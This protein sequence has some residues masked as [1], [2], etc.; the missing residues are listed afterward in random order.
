MTNPLP[1]VASQLLISLRS[2]MNP[3]GPT[4]QTLLNFTTPDQ[5]TANAGST[6]QII[7]PPAT[8]NYAVNLAT[9]FPAFLL[10]LFWAIFDITNPGIGF[11][12]SSNSGGANPQTVG[13]NGWLAWMGDGATAPST[14]YVTNASPTSE[15][16]LAI[17]AA[18]N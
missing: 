4:Q 1:A 15:L 16:V 18:S 2:Y 5:L 3:Q 14:I 17:T 12:F 8:T 7:I 6:Q 10:P 9:L 13:A 11:S